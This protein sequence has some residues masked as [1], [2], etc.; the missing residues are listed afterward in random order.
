MAAWIADRIRGAILDGVLADATVLP[1]SRALATELGVSRGVVTQAYQQLVDAG[2]AVGRG[3]AGTLV[4]GQS[5]AAMRGAAAVAGQAAGD[6]VEAL[7]H[8]APTP[9]VFERLRMLPARVDLTPGVPDLAAFP[10]SAWLHAERA[11]LRDVAPRAFGYADPRGTAELRSAV[12]NWLARNRGIRAGADEVIVVAGVAQGIAIAAR[13]L[14]ADGITRVGVEDPGSLGARQQV[15]AWGL[16]TRPIAVDDAGLKVGDLVR[17]RLRAVLVTPAHEFPMGVVLGG[18]RRRELLDWA[19][20]G[21]VVIEDDYDAEHRYDRA[22]VAALRSSRPDV[23]WYLGSVSKLLAP[24]LRIGWML[25]PPRYHDAAVEAK[26]DADLGNPSL[27]QCTLAAMMDSG[28]LERHLRLLRQRHRRRR[29]AMVAALDRHLP[30]ARVHGVAAG[31]HVTVT[32]DGRADLPDAQFAAAAARRGVKVHP[33]SWHRFDPTAAA[34]SGLVL[35]YAAADPEAITRGVATLGRI[36]R[37]LAPPA[38][39]RD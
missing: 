29:D 32:F 16:R 1:P 22:P 23:V 37:G 31:L 24:A 3:R 7:F 20:A 19:A 8:S 34:A 6:D 9:R 21:G 13:V 28:A 35:G 39:P 26:R 27:A 10:R 2:H 14:R 12:A 25:V 36:A 11:V 15:A 4:V 33:L 30:V 38:R 5:P 17:T 18:E